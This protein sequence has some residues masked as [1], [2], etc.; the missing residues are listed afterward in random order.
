MTKWKPRTFGI[1]SDTLF[2]SRYFREFLKYAVLLWTSSPLVNPL[3]RCCY[4]LHPHQSLVNRMKIVWRCRSTANCVWRLPVLEKP[5]E[6]RMESTG[7]MTGGAH[8]TYYLG[9]MDWWPEDCWLILHSPAALQQRQLTWIPPV[10]IQLQNWEEM[11]ESD[12][13]VSDF[14]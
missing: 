6:R 9:K 13:G 10:N 4:S 14:E 5:F 7:L 12:N 2:H 3:A 8:M 1:T 11:C